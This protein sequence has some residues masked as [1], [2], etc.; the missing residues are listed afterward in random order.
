[1]ARCTYKLT[2]FNVM[3]H[4]E[5]IRFIFVQAGVEYEDNRIAGKQWIKLKPSTP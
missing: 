1:M 4:A 3:G 2:Y 5:I